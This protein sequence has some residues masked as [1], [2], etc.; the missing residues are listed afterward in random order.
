MFIIRYVTLPPMR[1]SVVFPNKM[2]WN[3]W[4]ASFFVHW[5]FGDPLNQ[6]LLSQI[7]SGKEVFQFIYSFL[8]LAVRM[9]V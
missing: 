4:I 2:V 7:M 5:A 3:L 9:W 8:A 6:F 1:S